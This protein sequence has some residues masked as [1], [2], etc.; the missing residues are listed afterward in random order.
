MGI[1]VTFVDIEVKPIT[2]A[3]AEDFQVDEFGNLL[4]FADSYTAAG[5]YKTRKF[6]LVQAGRWLHAQNTDKVIKA[7]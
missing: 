5:A 2:Y 1:K 4:V 6:A 7:N 3:D